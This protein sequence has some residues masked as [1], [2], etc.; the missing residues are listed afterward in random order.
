MA[1]QNVRKFYS[2]ISLF[3]NNVFKYIVYL[4]IYLILSILR[5]EMHIRVNG[6]YN[7]LC[8]IWLYVINAS[9]TSSIIYTIQ[10]EDSYYL[11]WAH[12][13]FCVCYNIM[14]TVILQSNC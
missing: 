5:Y 14:I 12:W 10:T 1:L 13:M 9:L 4:S 6:Y 7:G 8:H 11:K 3:K 2:M